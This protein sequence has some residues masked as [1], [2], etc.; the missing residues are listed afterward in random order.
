[1]TMCVA[2]LMSTHSYAACRDDLKQLK[3]RVDR[4]KFSDRERYALANKWFGAARPGGHGT[5]GSVESR[6]GAMA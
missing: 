5:A 6:R 2:L 4:M 1:M 3:P